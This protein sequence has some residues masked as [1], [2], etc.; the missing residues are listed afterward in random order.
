M[1]SVKLLTTLHVLDNVLDAKK[2]KV[3][4]SL[5]FKN[6]QR[7]ISPQITILKGG[8]FKELRARW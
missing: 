8:I 6:I 3:G 4:M 1:Y 5:P 7:Q 2:G